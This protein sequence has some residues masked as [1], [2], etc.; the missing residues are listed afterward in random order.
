MSFMP[1]L[2]LINQYT[3]CCILLTSLS[4]LYNLRIDCSLTC[5]FLS[6]IQKVE[7]E[8]PL[9]TFSIDVMITEYTIVVRCQMDVCEPG[10]LRNAI[11]TDVL[12]C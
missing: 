4:N 7:R 5:S 12:C 8:H 2:Q 9:S 11:C 6:R 3:D 1:S 10:G